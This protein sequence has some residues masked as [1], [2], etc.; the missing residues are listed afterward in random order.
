MS[1]SGEASSTACTTA[2]VLLNEGNPIEGETTAHEEPK[3]KLWSEF[4]DDEEDGVDNE[5]AREQL[6][7]VCLAS[8][9]VRP[10]DV[11]TATGGTTTPPL[12]RTKTYRNTGGSP[13]S[14]RKAGSRR[15]GAYAPSW[16]RQQQDSLAIWQEAAA[17]TPPSSISPPTSTKGKRRFGG[18]SFD[19]LLSYPKPAVR[20]EVETSPAEEP[21]AESE[22]SETTTK[23]SEETNKDLISRQSDVSS[24]DAIKDDILSQRV[25][26]SHQFE[27]EAEKEVESD[28]EVM[29]SKQVDFS[30]QDD[31]SINLNPNRTTN[32]P[33]MHHFISSKGAKKDNVTDSVSTVSAVSYASS[34]TSSD[35]GSSENDGPLE[36]RLREADGDVIFDETFDI[37]FTQPLSGGSKRGL[38]KEVYEN[39][40]HLIGSFKNLSQFF[41][42]HGMLEWDSLPPSSV[43]AFCRHGVKPIWE[44]PA[45]ENGGRYLVKNFGRDCTEAVFTKIA[46][47]FF[48]GMLHDWKNYNL[49]SLHV[50]ES[51]RGNDIQLWRKVLHSH[52]LTTPIVKSD[53]QDFVEYSQPSMTLSFVPNKESLSRNDSRLQHQSGYRRMRRRG[54][55]ASGSGGCSSLGASSAASPYGSGDQHPVFLLYS[56]KNTTKSFLGEEQKAAI[57]KESEASLANATPQKAYATEQPAVA[58]NPGYSAAAYAAAAYGGYGAYYPKHD[59]DASMQLPWGPLPN[60]VDGSYWQPNCAPPDTFCITPY[61]ASYYAS[62]PVNGTV[63]YPQPSTPLSK[64]V[65]Q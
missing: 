22:A 45:N 5:L 61:A 60:V 51:R 8:V 64:P 43:I 12:Q 13:S 11:P 48:S 28:K 32:H 7:K 42:F 1:L 39:G 10:C 25:E 65:V 3:P 50:R 46:L 52:R 56:Q 47:G 2:A 57:L 6:R 55:R 35:D 14:Y 23:C 26:A 41:E 20:A 38:A 36:P 27:K 40:L 34:A 30:E 63:Y 17:S 18:L 59:E 33:P 29:T 19:A 15:G 54:G 16:K 58:Y 37:W 9:G 62:P 49:I 31:R 4:S 53:L 24:D 21:L 44:D